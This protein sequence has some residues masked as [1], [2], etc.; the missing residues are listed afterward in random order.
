PDNLERGSLGAGMGWP[1]LLGVLTM[2]AAFVALWTLR[3]DLEH[4][5]EARAKRAAD[6][7]RAAE[8]GR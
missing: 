6:A 5:R 7:L 2:L 1:F 4:L 3:I 8:E